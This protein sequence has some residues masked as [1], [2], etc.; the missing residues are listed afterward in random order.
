MKFNFKHTI[1]FIVVVLLVGVG[2][3]FYFNQEKEEE[4]QLDEKTLQEVKKLNQSIDSLRI[5]NNMMVYP[6][7]QTTVK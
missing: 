7:V 4:I 3:F 5:K 1:F 6:T 2:S